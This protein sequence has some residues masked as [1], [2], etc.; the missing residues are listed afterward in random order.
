[1]PSIE[2]NVCDDG[3]ATMVLHFS[4]TF[5]GYGNAA[6]QFV[7][8]LVLFEPL[9]DTGVMCGWCIPSFLAVEIKT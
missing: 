2:C 5:W 7:L 1:M 9:C 3:P 4:A 8:C 6:F